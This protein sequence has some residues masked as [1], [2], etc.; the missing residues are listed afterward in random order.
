MSEDSIPAA[1][2]SAS[3]SC[4]ISNTVEEHCFL[5]SAHEFTSYTAGLS[6]KRII[7]I[8]YWMLFLGA[9]TWLLLAHHSEVNQGHCQVN[10]SLCGWHHSFRGLLDPT[11]VGNVAVSQATLLHTGDIS[12]AFSILPLCRAVFH[13]YLCNYKSTRY[14]KRH[15]DICN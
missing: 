11:W 1:L 4:P 7:N 15:L 3:I 12:P 5:L 8:N 9:F 6:M 13:R 2:F 10:C 14:R